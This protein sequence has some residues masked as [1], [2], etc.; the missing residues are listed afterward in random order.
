[1]PE[2]VAGTAL[3]VEELLG[4]TLS[5]VVKA[6]GLIATQLADFIERVGFEPAADDE[7]PMRARTFSFEFNRAEVGEDDQVVSRRVTATLPLLSIVNLPALTIETA[8]IDMDLRLV[9]TDPAPDVPR[10]LMSTERRPIRLWAIPGRS[11]PTPPPG[12]P[13]GSRTTTTGALKVRVTLRRM[14]M[15]LGLERLE[16]LL[17]DGYVE[18]VDEPE[19]ID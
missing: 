3:L 16:R 2:P 11:V 12:Q 10:P 13:A 9:A 14:D 17:A 18:E 1:M 7:S 15:P 19:P 6:Q 8:D 4:S 5:S